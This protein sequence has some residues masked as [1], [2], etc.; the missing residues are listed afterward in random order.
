MTIA[1]L[2][3]YDLPELRDATDALWQ[4][5]ARGFRR[6]GIAEVPAALE[7]GLPYREV[8]HRADLRLS[9]DPRAGRPRQPR[10]DALLPR[11]SLRRPQ[12][13]QH[14]HRPRRSPR[15]GPCR[16]PRRA[17]RDQRHRLPVR[18]QRLARARRAA[19][20]KGPLL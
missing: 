20:R 10:R 2:A 16:P 5:L 8:W 12:L 11:R 7:R 18:L 4:G 19:R 17:L 15:N 14:R 13:L 1:S 6:A 3:M 9:A